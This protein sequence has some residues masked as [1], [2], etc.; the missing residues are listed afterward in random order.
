MIWIYAV[1]GK[2]FVATDV[3]SLTQL[4][5][6]ASSK[7]VWVDIFHPNEKELEILA[8]LFGNEPELVE[9]FKD[10]MDKPL[11][12]KVDGY[13]FCNYE[14]VHELAQSLFPQLM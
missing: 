7:W 10:M 6:I 3:A 12:V 8:E 14:K 1:E 9:K 11:D 4:R 2:D 5:D 13:E